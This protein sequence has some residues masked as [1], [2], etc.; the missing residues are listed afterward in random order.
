MDTEALIKLLEIDTEQI[1]SL[2][3]EV[4][5]SG[6]NLTAELAKELMQKFWSMKATVTE[7]I[8][9]AKRIEMMRKVEA[10]KTFIILKE[11]CDEKS[12]A[13]QERFAKGSPKYQKAN[14]EYIPATLVREFLHMKRVDLEQAHFM[15]KD[16]MR[17]QGQTKEREPD[18]S[19]SW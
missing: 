19:G 14:E 17:E 12:D 2:E 3:A 13:A 6:F 9:K 11:G 1:K 5:K 10:E 18:G 16:L 8:I 15:C 4:K 7:W